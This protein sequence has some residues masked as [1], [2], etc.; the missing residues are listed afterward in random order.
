MQDYFRKTI[1]MSIQLLSIS[2]KTAAGELRGR[3][4][5]DREQTEDILKQLTKNSGDAEDAQIDPHEAREQGV[6]NFLPFL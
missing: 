4:V 6:F 1:K 3:F 2:H 5:F